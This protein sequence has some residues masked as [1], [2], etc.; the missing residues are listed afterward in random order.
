M[1]ATSSLRAPRLRALPRVR[2]S[3]LVMKNI[4]AP[5]LALACALL[6]AACSSGDSNDLPDGW[7]GAAPV[8]S[9][10]QEECSNGD[11]DFSN[12]SASYTGGVGSIGVVYQDAHFRCVQKVE[13]FFKTAGDAVDILVQPIDMDPSSVAA[14]DCG[15]KITFLVEPVTAGSHTATLYRRWDNITQPNQPVPIT[16]AP[17]MV[18]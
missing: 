1:P 9:L 6:L 12:E 17:V 7:G 8:K 13:G 18:Q 16:A 4:V 3:L 10:V 15:Y 14:C 5:S 11:M 2:V